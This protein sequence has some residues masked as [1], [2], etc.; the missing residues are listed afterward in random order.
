MGQ[1]NGRMFLLDTLKSRGGQAIPA[2]S[3]VPTGEMLSPG[4]GSPKQDI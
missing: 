4:S 2:S 1:S 3:L